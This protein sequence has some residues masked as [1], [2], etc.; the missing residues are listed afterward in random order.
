MNLSADVATARSSAD[1]S[2][3][4]LLMIGIALV[5]PVLPITRTHCLA[6]STEDDASRCSM[7]QS[8]IFAARSGDSSAIVRAITPKTSCAVEAVFQSDSLNA[9]SRNVSSANC[10][11]EFT[12]PNAGMSI[13]SE[14]QS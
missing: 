11:G 6:T 10:V 12:E 14:G 5:D 13:D 9:S 2:F 7:A 4:N 3:M 1:E 8:T